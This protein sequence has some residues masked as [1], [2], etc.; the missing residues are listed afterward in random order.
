MIK[1]LSK[2]TPFY[3][4]ALKAFKKQYGDVAELISISVA[5]DNRLCGGQWINSAGEWVCELSSHT[6][7]SIE[8]IN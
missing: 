1:Q 6:V 4:E 7:H 2:S 3:Q 5:K 8:I